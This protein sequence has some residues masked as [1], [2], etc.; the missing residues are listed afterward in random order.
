MKI[1]ALS[2]IVLL[3]SALAFADDGT[4]PGSVSSAAP[5]FTETDITGQQT[6]SLESLRGKVVMLNF[7]GP[8]CQ[9]CR[10]EVPALE[11]VQDE[12]KGRLVVIGAAVFSSDQDVELFYRDFAINYPVI[13]GSYDLMDK[14]GR[15]SAFPTTIVIDQK[16]DIVG[17]LVGSRTRDQFEEILKP[18]LAD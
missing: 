1:S 9:P 8:W 12:Y 6:V 5:A 13:S 7:W 11:R 3:V 2:A 10:T 14:Y 4:D 16:G 18:L 17:T 15:V